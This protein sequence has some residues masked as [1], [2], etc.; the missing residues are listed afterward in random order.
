MPCAPGPADEEHVSL[1]TLLVVVAGAFALS[2]LVGESSTATAGSRACGTDAAGNGGYTYAGHQASVKGH[3]VRAT[4]MLTSAPRVEAGH[5]SGWVGVGGPGQGANGEDAWIQ[6]GVAAMH[7]LDPFLYAEVTRAG[8]QPQFILL[9]DDV[10]VGQS[11]KLAVLEMAGR[12]GWWRVWVDGDPVT[13]PVRLRGSSGRW[14]PIATAE[15]WNGGQVA[16]N[17]FAYRF[18]RVSVSYGSGG[19]W[20]PFVSAHRFLDGGYKLQALAT[21]PAE[22]GVY[23][24]RLSTSSKAPLPYAFLASS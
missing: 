8:R 20:K 7:G 9:E 14:A 15:S 1:R 22:D 23:A 17:T 21:A 16:C 6:V 19:S 13:Q 10:Q 24:R 4:I 12:P 3:G 2:A 18:E 11:R 5:V